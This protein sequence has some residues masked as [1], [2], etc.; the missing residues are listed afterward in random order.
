[1]IDTPRCNALESNPLDSFDYRAWV[2]LAKKLERELIA[3]ERLNRLHVE[4]LNERR[5]YVDDRLKEAAEIA[6]REWTAFSQTKEAHERNSPEP[7][8][9]TDYGFQYNKVMYSKDCM[10]RILALGQSSISERRE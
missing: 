10:D 3:M 8:R 7:F 2:T 1:M 6:G 5:E 9:F 4:Q